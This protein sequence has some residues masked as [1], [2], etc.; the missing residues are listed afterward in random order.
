MLSQDIFR[1]IHA[2]GVELRQNYATT[3]AGFVSCHRSGEIRPET[4]G[5]PVVGTELR[6]SHRGELLVRSQ[7]MFSG[8]YKDPAKTDQ[9]LVN[10]WC[11]TGDAANIGED[12]HLTVS[13]THLT[14]PTNREV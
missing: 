4:V 1:M 12:G 13:Y 9:V 7:N 10:G 11:R 3:E 5:R 6:V 14:L 8:Y 2:I